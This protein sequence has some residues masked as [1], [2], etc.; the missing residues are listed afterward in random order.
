MRPTLLLLPLLLTACSDTGDGSHAPMGEPEREPS[1]EIV[2]DRSTGTVMSVSADGRFVT[3]DHDPL[4]AIGMG[5]MRM[6]LDVEAGVD[7]SDLQEGDRVEFSIEAGE[8]IGIRITDICVPAREGE[9]CLS[10]N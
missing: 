10:E 4:P 6:G 5:A 8:S 9:G 2:T 1:R 7:V 3:M